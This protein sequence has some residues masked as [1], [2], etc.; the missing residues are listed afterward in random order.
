MILTVH[1]HHNL[2]EHFEQ[3]LIARYDST[4]SGIGMKIMRSVHFG[5]F[6][7]TGLASS[8]SKPVCFTKFTILVQRLQ[9]VATKQSRASAAS[10][11]HPW[12]MLDDGYGWLHMVSLNG[13]ILT[14]PSRFMCHARHAASCSAEMVPQSADS[15]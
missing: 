8:A 4:S 1:Y 7:T 12:M 11:V 13:P 10:A 9:H 2:F 14:M 15:R 6:P 5:H 3:F